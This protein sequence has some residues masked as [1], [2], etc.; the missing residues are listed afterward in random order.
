[1]TQPLAFLEA[2]HPFA[3]VAH[4]PSDS[5]PG[6][7]HICFGVFSP[8]NE[9]TSGGPYRLGEARWWFHCSCENFAYR[10]KGERAYGDVCKHV[11]A[12]VK[13]YVTRQ[14]EDIGK[15]SA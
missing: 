7:I 12:A 14:R 1:M 4:V 9:E 5:R 15:Q 13:E 10:S 11:E 3:F 2:A 8:G 6:L